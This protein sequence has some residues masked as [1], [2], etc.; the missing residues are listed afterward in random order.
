MNR[1]L[2]LP[3]G[4]QISVF[5]AGVKQARFMAWSPEGD[6]VLSQE[7]TPGEVVILP[8][9]NQDGRADKT[10]VFANKLRNP[11]GLAF[12]DGY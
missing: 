10:I 12:R 5:A 7:G 8:D 4:F 2:N 9:H 1:T 3:A 11:H 6:L